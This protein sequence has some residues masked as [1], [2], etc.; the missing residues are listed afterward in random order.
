[1]YMYVFRRAFGHDVGLLDNSSAGLARM[2]TKNNNNNTNSDNNS[3]S[4]YD[5]NTNNDTT[6]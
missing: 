2:N 3:N 4:D 6:C 1:M 5:D